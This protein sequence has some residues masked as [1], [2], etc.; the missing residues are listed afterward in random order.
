MPKHYETFDL[1]QKQRKNSRISQKYDFID[2]L[3]DLVFA[4]FTK[5][6]FFENCVKT[7]FREFCEYFPKS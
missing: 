3:Q 6:R 1:G 7:Y 2:I 5:I 4:N